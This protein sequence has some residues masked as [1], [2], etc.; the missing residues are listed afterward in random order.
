MPVLRFKPGRVEEVLGLG[1]DKA[2]QVM[3]KLKI[4]V[5]LDDEG[6]VVAELEVDRPDMYSLEGIARQAK[7]LLGVELGM[8]RYEIVES[9]YRIVAED[10]PTRPY[11]AGAVVWD[12]DV[13]EDFLEE[14]I[15]F[16]LYL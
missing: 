2:L 15:Q 4:E 9:G 11:V 13:D 14:L 12:V 7:G 16:Y 6:N 1:L 10:V 3:E 8:P 5:E